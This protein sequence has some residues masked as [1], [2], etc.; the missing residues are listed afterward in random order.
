MYRCLNGFS[1]MNQL[2]SVN[3]INSSPKPPALCPFFQGLEQKRGV[4]TCVTGGKTTF[5]DLPLPTANITTLILTRVATHGR[6][7]C[8]CQNTSTVLYVAR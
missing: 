3:T 5:N 7:V 4:S 8:A 1:K 6:V 2:I